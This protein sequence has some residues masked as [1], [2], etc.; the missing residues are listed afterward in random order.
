MVGGLRPKSRYSMGQA[1]AG[2]ER[3]LSAGE[4]ASPVQLPVFLGALG[5][6]SLRKEQKSLLSALPLKSLKLPI[7]DR[8]SSSIR[9][10]RPFLQLSAKQKGLAF[11]EGPFCEAENKSARTR[12]LT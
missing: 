2:S 7:K 4:A 12:Y 6:Q 11:P 1:R 3:P 8:F 9:T 5:S 10:D